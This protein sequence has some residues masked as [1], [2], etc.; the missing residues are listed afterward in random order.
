MS[1][2]A[3]Q[4][5][6]YQRLV[7]R[8]FQEAL[9]LNCQIELTY[10]CNHLCTFCY[11]SPSGAREM[12]T[13]Q[14]FQVLHKVADLGVLYLTLTGGEAL[15]H[16][17]FFKIA[18]EVRRLGMA[19]RIYS[20]GYLLADKKVVRQVKELHPME[21]EISIHGSKPEIHEALT[22]IKGSFSRTVKAVENLNEAGVKVNLKCPITK[23]NQQDLFEIKALAHSLGRPIT[24]DA[25]ITPKDDGNLDPLALRPDDA[26]V[27]RYWGEW[28]EQLHDG[29]LP[30]RANHCA[31]DSTANC[32]TGRAGFTIDP[33][34][35]LFPCVAFRRKAT[36]VL[37]ITDLKEVWFGSPV[38]KEV[39]D[40][41]VEARKTL[42]AT[43]LGPYYI[44]CLGVAETQTG[45]P[46]GVYPQAEVNAK[47][48]RRHYELLQIGDAL[49]S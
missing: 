7:N 32:G 42:D 8:A 37:E 43:P 5:N 3:T 36:N 11:N 20:N 29:Q 2:G 39:R 46:L 35:N 49:A 21:V 15:C 38:L 14:I 44:F 19:L 27:E 9:P 23:L 16:K 18:H 25:V 10:R 13:D 1:E 40:L 12:T 22:R 31:A 28:Y 4:L 6:P 34:G 24:F 45:D 47:A 26:F 41:S 17:D 30:P 33:Y 48:V